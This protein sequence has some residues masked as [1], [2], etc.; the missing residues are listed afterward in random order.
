MP[1]TRRLD[2]RCIPPPNAI[3]GEFDQSDSLNWNHCVCR[4]QC[5]FCHSGGPPPTQC[6]IVC[7][8]ERCLF[9]GCP[10]ECFGRCLTHSAHSTAVTSP[11]ND[12]DSRLV[13]FGI[14]LVSAGFGSV[15][16]ESRRHF[17]HSSVTHLPDLVTHCG[18]CIL[19]SRQ[20]VQLWQGQN[21][22]GI[23]VGCC[24]QGCLAGTNSAVP[25][26]DE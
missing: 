20:V 23:R 18:Q 21:L 7:V 1:P 13:C 26:P 5:L 2:H 17:Q 19:V 25:P 10:F 14:G 3:V 24:H 8:G 12:C 11:I 22:S 6:T 4:W 9:G 16:V 15:F